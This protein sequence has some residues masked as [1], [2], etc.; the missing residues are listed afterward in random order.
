MGLEGDVGCLL[1]EF[2]ELGFGL[3]V[4][5]GHF[6]GSGGLLFEDVWV[7]VLFVCV[8]EEEVYESFFFL[9]GVL[10]REEL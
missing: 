1:G 2:V 10:G 4:D 7:G 8:G 6:D 9:G 3:D 5:D